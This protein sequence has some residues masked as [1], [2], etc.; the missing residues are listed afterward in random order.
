MTAEE[1]YE[2][3]ITGL[4]QIA[5]IAAI[6]DQLLDPDITATLRKNLGVIDSGDRREPCGIEPAN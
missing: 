2:N 5:Q 6:D 4:E 1:H 3:A